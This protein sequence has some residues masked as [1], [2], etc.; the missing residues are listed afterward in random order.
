[1][2]DRPEPA[3]D[4]PDDYLEG[5]DL[6]GYRMYVAADVAFSKWTSWCDFFRGRGRASP[7]SVLEWVEF[8]KELARENKGKIPSSIVLQRQ[9]TGLETAMRKY[10]ESFT[11]FEQ[12]RKYR[13]VDQW[14][15]IAKQM[16][17]E[18]GGKLPRPESMAEEFSGLVRAMRVYPLRFIDV[19]VETP[20]FRTTKRWLELAEKLALENGG[21]LPCSSVLRKSY[22][23]LDRVRRANPAM[24]VHLK[25][26]SMRK[27]LDE[28]VA[29]AEK[30]AADN[31]GLLPRNS[32]L[33]A[34]DRGLHNPLYKYPEAFSHIPRG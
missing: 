3:F 30:I 18:N 31:N 22:R 7:K 26:E 17:I 2:E 10:P 27:T 13:S 24:F 14:V 15:E 12:D 19:E 28:W 32:D 1:M 9:Y 16:S 5:E 20:L 11:E 4:I 21:L 29:I 33:V 6:A 25:I 8:A 34:I 23:Q